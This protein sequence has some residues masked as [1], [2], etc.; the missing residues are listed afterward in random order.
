[1]QTIIKLFVKI[2][3]PRHTFDPDHAINIYSTRPIKKGEVI[4]ATYTNSLWSTIDRRDHL[5]MSKCFWYESKEN[6]SK[7]LLFFQGAPASA[8]QTQQNTTL[9]SPLFVVLA[10][11]VSKTTSRTMT[12]SS[13]FLKTLSMLNQTGGV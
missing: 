7:I 2:L 12:S 10:V 6:F 8:A 9:T 11:L 3:F 5:K 13:W 4:T 1:M